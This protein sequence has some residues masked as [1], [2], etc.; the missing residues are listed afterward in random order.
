MLCEVASS[1]VLEDCKRL[2]LGAELSWSRGELQALDAGGGRWGW[3]GGMPLKTFSAPERLE[4][5][6]SVEGLALQAASPL[7]HCMR[8][9]LGLPAE[10]SSLGLV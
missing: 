1:P 8:D 2:S 4:S 7:M 5:H 3:L 10:L 9:S 6:L